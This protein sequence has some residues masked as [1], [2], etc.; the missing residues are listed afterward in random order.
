MS[1]VSSFTKPWLAKEL[2]ER[3]GRKRHLHSYKR[4]LWVTVGST[5]KCSPVCCFICFLRATLEQRFRKAVRTIHFFSIKPCRLLVAVSHSPVSVA[6]GREEPTGGHGQQPSE[7]QRGS[8]AALCGLPSLQHHQRDA[9][10]NL[11][12]LWQGGWLL[13]RNGGGAGCM[14]GV[15]VCVCLWRLGV[16]TCPFASPVC[17]STALC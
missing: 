15:C 12:A 10:W 11:R 8:H 16:L 17:R 2:Q 3:M 5:S 4:F 13:G 14:G 7:R 9:A 6:S 1:Q